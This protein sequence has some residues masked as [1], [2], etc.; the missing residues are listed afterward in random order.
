MDNF[1]RI[2]AA[3]IGLGIV[4]Q[5]IVFDTGRDLY[6]FPVLFVIVVVAG[7][8]LEP[9]A[10]GEPGRRPS[11]VV[12]AGRP[13]GAAHPHR[14]PV[15]P[16]VRWAAAVPVALVLLLRPDPPALAARTASSRSPPS[17]AIISI[18]AVSLVLLTGW[19]G[20]VSLGQMAFAAVG[21]AVGALGHPDRRL[22]PRPRPAGGGLGGRGRGHRR[23]HPRGT[24]RGA[25]AG[26]HHPG[27]G[28]RRRSSGCST[29]SSST[30]CRAAASTP[31]PRCSARIEI[32]SQMSFYFLTLGVLAVRDRRCLRD[33]PQPHRPR[34]HRAAGEPTGRRGLRHQLA[35]D[36][37]RRVRL[38][39]LRRR[40]RRRAARPPPARGQP[41]RHQQ[42]VLGRGQPACVLHRRDRWDGVGARRDPRR[43][44][45]VRHAVLHAPRVAVPRHRLRAPGHPAD[46]ARAGSAQGSPR[47]ATA[48]SAGSPRGATSSCRAWSP[49]GA[50]TRSR[51]RRRWPRPSPRPLERP[52]IEEVVEL[53][54]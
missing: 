8:L 10:N 21:G 16:E 31:T 48:S 52:E 28:V 19:A 51:R 9:R 38:L 22:G 5:A 36:D 29:P 26:R 42:P 45:R 3:A 12:L 32:E 54:Q 18:V 17:P 34:A 25:H 41:G 33:P 24:R 27:A 46:P 53:G 44:L 35:A 37:A 47:P 30:G 15:D 6:V 39:R 7:L 2:A 49:T 20:H 1:P 11:R 14:A 13:R 23:G 43:R 4:E 40:H 50:T